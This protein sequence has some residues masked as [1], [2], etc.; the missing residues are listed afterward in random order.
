MRKSV[1]VFIAIFLLAGLAKA[2]DVEIYRVVPSKI[3]Y[4]L[5]EDARAD[6]VMKNNTS[7]ARK[8]TLVVNELR[9]LDQK[10]EVFSGK[11]DLAPNEEKIV[12]VTWNVGQEMWGR[13]LQAKIQIDDKTVS[14]RTEFF[15][16]ADEWWRVVIQYWILSDDKETNE[17]E[18]TKLLEYFHLPVNAKSLSHAVNYDNEYDPFLGYGNFNQWHAW[19]PSDFGALSPKEESWFSGQGR[20]PMNKKEILSQI[21]KMRKFGMKASA[22]TANFPGG[23]AGY[24]FARQHPEWIVREESGAF[25]TWEMPVSPLDMAKP[26]SERPAMWCAVNVDGYWPEAVEY[27]AKELVASSEMFDWDAWYFDFHYVMMP[28]YSWDGQKTQHGQNPDSI[29]ARNVRLVRDIVL[30]KFPKTWF[31]QNGGTRVS[32][33]FEGNMIASNHGGL[34]GRLAMLEHPQNGTLN[35]FQGRQLADPNNVKHNWRSLFEVYIGERDTR[36]VKKQAT[37]ISGTVELTGYMF[38]WAFFTQMS[39]EEFKATRDLWTMSNHFNS[40]LLASNIHPSNSSTWSFRPTTQFMTRYSSLLWDPKINVV[41]KPGKLIRVDSLREVWWEECV[42]TKVTDKYADVMI[43]IIN[44]PVKEGA[45]PKASEDPPAVNDAEISF[46]I[47]DDSPESYK[48]WALQ[49]YAYGA[50]VLEPV[51]VELK[52]KFK[53]KSL[54]FELP[55]FNYYTLVVIRQEKKKN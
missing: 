7:V 49:P 42:Y 17:R 52:S 39:K 13:G 45:D 44:S 37:D 4:N 50:K 35:E 22:Y 9:D 32:G 53:D 12:K 23:P 20:Y 2:Q 21:A 51:Q 25:S 40:L 48:V 14:E 31:W 10:R 41:E 55:P 46:K 26:L 8:A 36:M 11:L 1:F 16:V 47:G 54:V 15:S 29:S 30:K 34:E 28:G 6:V 5:N 24:E 19:A 18:K 33:T 27:G 38:N 3:L 43:H